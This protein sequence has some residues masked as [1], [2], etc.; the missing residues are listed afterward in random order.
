MGRYFTRR[1]EIRIKP[2]EEDIRSYLTARLSNDTEPGAMNQD[3]R[4]EIF[5]TIPEKISDMYVTDITA[6]CANTFIHRSFTNKF[7]DFCLFR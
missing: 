1:V 3:L 2:A 4:E 5:K 6:F 7:V